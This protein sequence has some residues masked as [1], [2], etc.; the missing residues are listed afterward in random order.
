MMTNDQQT[1]PSRVKDTGALKV[2]AQGGEANGTPSKRKQISP[3]QAKDQQK[4]QIKRRMK[5]NYL[6]P[7]ESEMGTVSEE[8]AQESKEPEWQKVET[9]KTK[10]KKNK[11]KNDPKKKVQ[12]KQ[13]SRR[14]RPCALG[15]KPTEGKTYADVFSKVKK[16]IIL[17]DVGLAVAGVRKM[18][19]GDVLLIL[20]KDN[21]GKATEIGEKI[22]TVLGQDAT[23]NARIPEITLE[24]TRLDATTTK[25]EVYQAVVR[26]LGSGH[27]IAPEAVVSVRMTYGGMQTALLKLPAQA[28]RELLEK[29]TM[30][31]NWS[32]VRVRELM[33]PTK[34]FRCWQHG[35]GDRQI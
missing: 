24:V 29:Q 32:S 21:Q 26:E 7:I 8:L 10:M 30:R 4:R 20:N 17:Q 12:T 19:S 13:R 15:I 35:L 18:L 23:I 9:K 16:V 2:Q 27:S 33:R 34:C 5:P 22:G 6:E 1:T 14:L 3:L 11:E 28:A 31:V 25:D